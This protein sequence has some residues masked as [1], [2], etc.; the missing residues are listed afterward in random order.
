MCERHEEVGILC[1]HWTTTRPFPQQKWQPRMSG[2]RNWLGAT[3]PWN[4][5]SK[6]AHLWDWW[7]RLEIQICLALTIRENV[8][9]FLRDFGNVTLR[10]LLHTK[11]IC[12]LNPRCPSVTR[13][14]A[15]PPLCI[16]GCYYTQKTWKSH[17]FSAWWI[18]CHHNMEI[19]W[20]YWS[21][22]RHREIF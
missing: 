1:S 10:H 19:W 13:G 17:I 2:F 18:W 3:W 6:H 12:R 16:G 15:S 5:E 14:G 20:V 9:R 21:W 11:I 8:G 4:T 22:S 7:E